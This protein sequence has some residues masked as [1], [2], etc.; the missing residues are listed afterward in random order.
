MLVSK[1]A[2]D[3]KGTLCEFPNKS[4]TR[5]SPP[6]PSPEANFGYVLALV[7]KDITGTVGKADLSWRAGDLSPQ[8]LG[9]LPTP[10]KV[11]PRS[12]GEPNQA[13]CLP[14]AFFLLYFSG[15]SLV[16][17]ITLSSFH[18][19]ILFTRSRDESP[20]TTG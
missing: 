9:F 10:A 6:A 15:N 4:C 13:P 18:L 3:P 11:P 19:K 2:V 16:T 20:G 5:L 12:H 8:P 14:E 17:L 7:L 1:A